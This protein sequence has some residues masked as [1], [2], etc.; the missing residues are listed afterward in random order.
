MGCT[1]QPRN[2][3]C[4]ALQSTQL[5]RPAVATAVAALPALT[6]LMLPGLAQLCGA[7]RGCSP[8]CGELQALTLCAAVR[9][10][11]RQGWQALRWQ[12]LS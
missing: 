10:V 12:G 5:P 1:E 2:G 9:E 3:S 4:T 7:H 8:V 11:S 6:C